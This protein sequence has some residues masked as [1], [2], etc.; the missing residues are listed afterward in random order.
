MK[1]IAS[2]INNTMFHQTLTTIRRAASVLAGITF[3]GRTALRA[4][5]AFAVAALLLM[6]APPRVNAQLAIPTVSTV[7]FVELHCFQTSGEGTS[8]E[9]Y[10]FFVVG[11]LVTGQLMVGRTSVFGDVDAGENRFQTVRLWGPNG[12]AASFPNGNPDNLVILVGA[13]EHD[14]SDVANLLTKLQGFMP[15][16]FATLRSQ[17]LAGSITRASLVTQLTTTFVIQEQSGGTGI[18]PNA[19]D[20]TCRPAELRITSTDI[21]AGDIVK[22]LDLD[23]RITGD[24]LYRA[25]FRIQSSRVL[26]TFTR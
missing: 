22:A 12:V 20:I 15:S 6:M 1:N 25:F 9:P 23:G 21:A 17:L 18:F 8:D 14:N 2:A 19:D 11:N 7:D 5:S 4:A 26:L 24:G 3:H 13:M 16:R 10:L